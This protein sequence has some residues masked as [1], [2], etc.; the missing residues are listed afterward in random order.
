MTNSAASGPAPKR[1]FLLALVVAIAVT[2]WLLLRVNTSAAAREC[3]AAYRA[4]RTA[5][6]SAAVDSLVPVPNG[7]SSPERCLVI[8]T[9]ARW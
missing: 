1:I 3:L 7:G 4:A 8:R 5:A 9:S 6:D 2:G